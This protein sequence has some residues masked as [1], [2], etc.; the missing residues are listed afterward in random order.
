MENNLPLGIRL[1]III[2]RIQMAL[3]AISIAISGVL[4]WNYLSNEFSPA[5]S[6][7]TDYLIFSCILLLMLIICAIPL[8]ILY[9]LNKKIL[10]LDESARLYQIIVSCFFILCFPLGTILYALVLYHIYC[11]PETKKVFLRSESPAKLKE[12]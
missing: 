11:D 4:L 9:S 7:V 8:I 2:N 1:I 12:L 3:C 10:L 6:S 5:G